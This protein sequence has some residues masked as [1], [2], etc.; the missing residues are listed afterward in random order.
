MKRLYAGLAYIAAVLALSSC[1]AT[2]EDQLT[3]LRSAIENGEECPELFPLLKEI[4]GDEPVVGEAQAEM[5]NIGCYSP[6]SERTDA[7]RSAIDPD[8]DWIGVP[9]GKRV[10]VSN[11]C[12]DVS[13][14][15]ATEVDY[16][17][18]EQLIQRTLEV[19]QDTNEWLSAVEKYPGVM[20]MVDGAIPSV[21]DIQIAC[22][23]YPDTAVCTDFQRL[24][25][26]N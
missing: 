18:A 6:T 8:S 14:Q 21:S 16:L 20:G 1:S 25:V 5:R 2:P 3:D 7:E 9:E 22:S 26:S 10:D 11:A 13:E 4:P 15:A 17:A 24:G 23:A 19:C 12:L